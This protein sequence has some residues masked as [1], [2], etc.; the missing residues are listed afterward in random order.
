MV[1]PAGINAAATVLAVLCLLYGLVEMKR[2]FPGFFFH[3]DGTVSGM[4][5]ASWEGPAA[6]L[7][8]GDRIVSVDGQPLDDGRPLAR[9]L[10]AHQAGEEVTFGV[11]SGGT[12]ETSWVKLKLRHF[13]T[14]DI[15]ATF[16]LPYGIGV[17]YLLLGAIVYF[18]K[19]AYGPALAMS[20]SVVAAVYY[21]TTFDAHT[22]FTFSRLW[23]SYPLLGALS[24]HLFSVFPARRPR[25]HRLWVLAIPYTIAAGI[26][27]LSQLTLTVAAHS[28]LASA[29]NSGFLGACFLTDIW[30]LT[31]TIRTDPSEGIRNKARTIRVGLLATVAVALVFILFVRIYPGVVTTEWALMLSALFPIILAYAVIKKNIFDLDL[32]L[33]T[34]TTYVIATAL[35]IALYFAVVSVIGLAMSALTQRYVGFLQTGVAAVVSTLVVALLFNPLRLG[36]QRLVDRFFFREKGMLQQALGEL[37]TDL[38]SRTDRF[39]ELTEQLTA[40]AQALLRCQYALLL[41]PDLRGGELQAVSSAGAVP[42]ELVGATLAGDSALARA[43]FESDEPLTEW[44]DVGA[45]ATWSAAGVAAILSLRR[46]KTRSGLLLLGPRP[47]GDIFTRFDLGLMRS[48]APPAGL[49][50][51][52]ALLLRRHAE[53]ER[54]AA[55]GKLS[56]VIIHEI[57]N[58]LGIIRVSSG[59]LKKRFEPPDSGHELASF[60]EEEVVRMNDTVTQFLTF[61]RP[62][63]PVVEAFDLAQLVRQ[64]ASVARA[65]L[66][67]ATIALE[68]QGEE[69]VPALGDVDQ[70]R[71][72]VLNLLVNAKQALAGQDDR[73]ISLSC[74]R[75][76]SAAGAHAE[77]VV[78][79]NG[80]GIPAADRAEIFEPFY[81]TRPGGTGLGLAIA[82][83]LLREQG[84]RIRIQDREGGG[85]AF[86]VTLPAPASGR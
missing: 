5:R 65:D 1:I 47:H 80:P 35:V 73:R 12:G 69:E 48:L 83:Q 51:E 11:L 57:K 36:V 38:A 6:G 27:A 16:V 54:L 21:T 28:G 75:V 86:R 37:T 77:L 66:E 2:V 45:G 7:R 13:T 71:R 3:P 62:S 79:N 43:L 52:N 49:V 76:T 18:V 10:A 58:P 70:L 50:L 4:Q 68:L 23:V 42:E 9:W 33:R 24:I 29:L 19:R 20:V 63:Q 46:G 31:V 55:L 84:G 82:R 15:L 14:G 40:R 67:Q 17:I 30:L 53:R 85:V 72:V 59:T 78:A 8:P 56:A 26:I 25:V 41:C 34:T 81:T 44:T 74:R 64:T 32:V 60:I 61:A 22:G 39:D